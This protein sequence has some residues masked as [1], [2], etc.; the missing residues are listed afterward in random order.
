MG[1]IKELAQEV[2]DELNNR[3]LKKKF[4][5]FLKEFN[6][7][8][9]EEQEKLNC[10]DVGCPISRDCSISGCYRYSVCDLSNK[11]R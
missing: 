4:E 5:A 2:F 6:K 7:L 11:K 9:E 1:T 10:N 3:T 8:V